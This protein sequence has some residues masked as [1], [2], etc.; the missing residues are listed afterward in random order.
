VVLGR[1]VQSGGAQL[2]VTDWIVIFT[3]PFILVST[4][5][6]IAAYRGGDL[7]RHHER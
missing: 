4:I 5:M 6:V 3:A 2:S 1:R 7:K